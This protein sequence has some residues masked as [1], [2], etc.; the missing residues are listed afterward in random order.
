MF[1]NLKKHGFD[2]ERTMLRHFERLSRLTLAAALIYFWLISIG[3]RIVRNS[4][5]DLVDCKT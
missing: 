1:G 2:L 4:L 5:R 3:I